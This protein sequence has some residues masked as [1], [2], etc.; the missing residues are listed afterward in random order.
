[1]THPVHLLWVT[2]E[3]A[4]SL[5]RLIIALG[6]RYVPYLYT[7]YRRTGTLWD[8]RDPSSLIQAEPYRLSSQRDM[9]LNPVRAARVDDPA[10]DRWPSYRHNALGQANP[11]RL[12]HPLYLA[13]GKDD[14]TR[15]ASCRSLFRIVLDNEALRDIRLALNQNP[16][17][18]HLHFYAKVEATTGQR[19]EPKPCGRPRKPPD[20]SPAHD[21]RQGELPA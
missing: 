2:P 15:Q 9:E 20:D 13:L 14:K 21:A 7:T 19:R 5:P 10:H 8:S 17:L 3:R 6:R 4:A 16:P 1:M 11:Y 18:G 12:P